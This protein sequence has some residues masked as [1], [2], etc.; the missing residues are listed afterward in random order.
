MREEAGR[1]I[2]VG[3]EGN[4]NTEVIAKLNPDVIF[5]SPFKTG[6][7]DV[8]KNM[9]IPLVPMGAYAEETPLGRAEWIKMMAGM[10]FY[11]LRRF[12][13]PDKRTYA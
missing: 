12:Y 10:Y 7:Y 6:G 1:I 9:G 2:K 4:F 11:Q 8:L 5:V 13:F 3:K